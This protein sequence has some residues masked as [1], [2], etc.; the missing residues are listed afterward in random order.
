MPV[1]LLFL[2]C[3]TLRAQPMQALF[4]LTDSADSLRS[5]YE[6]ARQID[7]LVPVWYKTDGAGNVTGSPHPRVLQAAR[8]AGVAVMPIIVNPG[9]RKDIFQ[10]LANTTAFRARMIQTLV[11]ECRRY[12]YAGIQ[13]DF[14]GVAVADRNALTRLVEEAAAAFHKAGFQLSLA[15]VPRSRDRPAGSPYSQHAWSNLQ[16][17]YDVP[18]LG[19]AVDFLTWM[20]YDQHMR[21]TTPGP[22]AA[23]P[24]VV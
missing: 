2:F 6:H 7:I 18:K 19:A 15:A 14:E 24:W 3:F 11:G 23:Y 20:T 21:L 22:V 16:G 5:F 12:G 17:A 10:Q 8:A 1:V 13:L 4:Y 9:F